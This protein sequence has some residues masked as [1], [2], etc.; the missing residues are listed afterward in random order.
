MTAVK[1]QT[2]HYHLVKVKGNIAKTKGDCYRAITDHELVNS[3]EVIREIAEVTGFSETHL[4]Y[5]GSTIFETMA[6]RTLEDGKSR[7]FGEWLE[8][9][10]DIVGSTNRIDAP[11]DPEELRLKINLVPGKRIEEL[12]RRQTPVNSRS[13]ARGKIDYVSYPGGDKGEIKFGEDILIFGEDIDLK[14]GDDVEL[15]F[16]DRTGWLW[17]GGETLSD[18]KKCLIVEHDDHHLRVKWIGPDKPEEIVGRKATIKL[19]S[20][21]SW[22]TVV[23]L[24]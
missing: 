8:T 15:S 9:R 20:H 2:I 14:N 19:K 11:F 16:K 1:E 17:R 3:R 12:T 22:A 23:T 21:G 4:E 6:K 24:I 7:R 18:D 13:S 10:L 5:I